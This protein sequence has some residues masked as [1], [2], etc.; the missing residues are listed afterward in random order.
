MLDKTLVEAKFPSKYI[1]AHG[2]RHTYTS[3]SAE[4][5]VPLDDIRKQLSHTKDDLTTRVYRHVT[6]ARRRADVDKLDALIGDLLECGQV[7][8]NTPYKPR[9]TKGST[10]DSSYLRE[11]NVLVSYFF[12][13]YL[14]PTKGECP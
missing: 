8:G 2:L 14:L 3:L 4:V 7:V 1:T 10:L 9:S 12:A 6:E 13:T 5:G 11:W